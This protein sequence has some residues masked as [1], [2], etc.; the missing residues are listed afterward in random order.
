MTQWCKIVLADLI[1]EVC[2]ALDK[3]NAEPEKEAE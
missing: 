1:R 3:M 2:E